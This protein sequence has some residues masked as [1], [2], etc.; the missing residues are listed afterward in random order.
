MEYSKLLKDIVEHYGNSE[1]TI[2]CSIRNQ[3]LNKGV[4]YN[5]YLLVQTTFSNGAEN[6]Y[7]F[8][9]LFK[10]IQVS[11]MQKL[12]LM[13]FIQELKSYSHMSSDNYGIAGQKA[14]FLN[15]DIYDRMSN[16]NNPSKFKT[17]MKWIEETVLSKNNS[18]LDIYGNLEKYFYNENFTTIEKNPIFPIMRLGEPRLV[19]YSGG[20]YTEVSILVGFSIEL[21]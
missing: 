14:I 5:F 18:N 7:A 10:D 11:Y 12:E 8:V 1:N 3:F 21:K 15:C 2:N 20:N 9:K 19:T 13:H 17:I 6:H 4:P 16:I